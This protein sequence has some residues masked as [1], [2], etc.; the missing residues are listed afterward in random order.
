MTPTPR[1]STAW[2]HADRDGRGAAPAADAG[3]CAYC[4]ARPGVVQVPK[5]AGAYMADEV[6]CLACYDTLD[7]GTII[8]VRRAGH[9]L[10]ERVVY[11]SQ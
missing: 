1:L 7:T 4:G 6:V 3:W 8:G 10:F 5:V 2:V 11:T 9:P